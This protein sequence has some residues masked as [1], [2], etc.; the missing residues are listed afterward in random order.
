M[1]NR[2]GLFIAAGAAALLAGGCAEYVA[3]NRGADLSALGYDKSSPPAAGSIDAALAKRPLARF[4]AAIAIARIESS[5]YESET[6]QGWGSGRYSIVTTRD[7]EDPA[8]MDKWA[9]LPQVSGIA[10]ISHMLLPSKLYSDEELRHAA[11]DLHADMLLVYTI[12]TKFQQNDLAAPLTIVT[13]GLAP[14]E[15]IHVDCTASAVLMDTRNGYIYGAC[16]ESDHGNGLT[17]GWDTDAAV[18]AVRRQVE[19]NAFNKMAARFP[20]AW[21]GVVKAYAEPVTTLK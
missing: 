18:D 7:I 14:D 2:L 17:I 20:E 5:G 8:A 21:K 12:D 3:P 11:A 19:A 10:T 6:A 4:P 15:K 9:Q 13:L 1:A 16:E